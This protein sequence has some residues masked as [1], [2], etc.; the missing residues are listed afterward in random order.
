MGENERTNERA[1]GANERDERNERMRRTNET[2]ERDKR[3]TRTNERDERDTPG[4]TL[5]VF[6]I[7]KK[8]CGSFSIFNIIPGVCT[9]DIGAISGHALEHLTAKIQYSVHI[10]CWATK[11]AGIHSL[12]KRDKTTTMR[13]VEAYV[14]MRTQVVKSDAE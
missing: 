14:L 10:P 4:L 1:N 7:E 5:L 2:N 8:L 12:H 3:T 11:R 9:G 13:H 6:I